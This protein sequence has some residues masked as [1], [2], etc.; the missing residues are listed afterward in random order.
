MVNGR[1]NTLKK[2]VKKTSKHTKGAGMFDMLVNVGRVRGQKYEKW[3][4][5]RLVLKFDDVDFVNEVRRKFGY[6][7]TNITGRGQLTKKMVEQEVSKRS[8]EDKKLLNTAPKLKCSSG[9]K[10]RRSKKKWK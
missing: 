9:G 4:E 7:K 8:E 2:S 6:D 3:L 10:R 5:Q 1:N